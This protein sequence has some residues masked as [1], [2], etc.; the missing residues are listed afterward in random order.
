MLLAQLFYYLGTRSRTIPQ[1]LFSNRL[2]KGEDNLRRK[3]LGISRKRSVENHSHQFPVTAGGVFPGGLLRHH[4][5]RS[6]GHLC[7]SYTLY[8]FYIS[9]AQLFHMR[10]LEPHLRGD[11]SQGIASPVTIARS[12]GQFPYAKAIYNHQDNSVNE[13]HFL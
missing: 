7:R 9:D 12:I 11:I 13:C 3:S 5:K 1:N 10:N 2:F 8:L 4:A 6:E